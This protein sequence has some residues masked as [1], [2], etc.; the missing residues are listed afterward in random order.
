MSTY[1]QVADLIKYT[2]IRLNTDTDKL[3]QLVDDAE[4]D[5][6]LLFNPMNLTD[7]LQGFSVIGG[8]PTGGSWSV[9][10]EWL[11]DMY[12]SDDIAWN[13]QGLDVLNA[14]NAMTDALGNT[15]QGPSWVVPVTP[16]SAPDWANGPLPAKPVVLEATSYMGGQILPLFTA[17]SNFTADGDATPEILVTQFRGGGTRWDI[18]SIE[19]FQ[20]NC[21]RRATC[22]QAE[23]RDQMG[24]DFFIRAQYASVTGPEFQT[25]GQL[26]L[27]GPKAR[28][29]LNGSGLI[30]YQARAVVGTSGS[31]AYAYNRLGGTPIPDDWRAV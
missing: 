30:Q 9:V 2:R 5:V 24:E 8:V 3:Q 4:Q 13:A 15:V 17:T 25:T 7:S 12:M 20:I 11:S 26:P 18:W 1:A 31:M 19:P 6:D 28:R 27:I 14:I 16:S 22:A 29:E 10:I 23:Y 21:L